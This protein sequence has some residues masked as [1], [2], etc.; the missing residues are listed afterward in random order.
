MRAQTCSLHAHRNLRRVWFS[1]AS[2]LGLNSLELPFQR[3]SAPIQMV[4]LATCRQISTIAVLTFLFTYSLQAEVQIGR[5]ASVR[6]VPS[7]AQRDVLTTSVHFQFDNKIKTVGDAVAEVLG[8]VG[9]RLSDPATA[10]PHRGRLLS[11]PLPQPHRQLGPLKARD[12]LSTLVGPVWQV[13]E[14]PVD[15]LVSFERCGEID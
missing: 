11:L 8:E 4:S 9:Y 13:L 1:F 15:R 14:D 5:Y 3:K 2:I 10:D 6:E 12:A 7:D